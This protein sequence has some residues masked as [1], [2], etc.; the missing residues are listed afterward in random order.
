MA[1]RLIWGCFRESVWVGLGG[2]KD[3]LSDVWLWEVDKEV[4]QR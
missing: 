1:W 2:D 3:A 4:R